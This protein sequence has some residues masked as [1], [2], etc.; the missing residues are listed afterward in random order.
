MNLGEYKYHLLTDAQE[1]GKR[2]VRLSRVMGT[3]ARRLTFYPTVTMTC[4]EVA[5][6]RVAYVHLNL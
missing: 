2:E 5:G 1:N 3:I 4:W 6:S